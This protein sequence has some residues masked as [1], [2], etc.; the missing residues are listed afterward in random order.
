MTRSPNAHRNRFGFL[1]AVVLLWLT[2]APGAAQ[3]RVESH[4]RLLTP[5]E[6]ASLPAPPAS[7]AEPSWGIQDTITYTLGPCD[8]TV[9]GVGVEASFGLC[10]IIKPSVSQGFTSLAFPIHLPSGAVIE[11]ITMNY[12]DNYVASNP[13]A[14]LYRSGP[15]GSS[16]LILDM[17]P[18]NTAGGNV[19]TTFTPAAPIP[20]DNEGT[21]YA[22]LLLLHLDKASMYEGLYSYSIRYRLQ[23]SPAPVTATFGDVPVGHVFHRY[24]EALAA[25]GITAGCGSG[26]FCPDAALTRGQM[27]AFLSIALGLHF[28]D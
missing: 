25:S 1:P 3:Q 19:L 4:G 8:A 6:A 26:N 17:N 28:P 2:A 22:I 10:E 5:E 21:S 13:T 9:R 7:S 23:V 27:A 16:E 15:T 20:I 11:A 18:P 14:G 24:I 12:Y